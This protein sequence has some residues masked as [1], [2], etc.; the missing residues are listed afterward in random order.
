MKANKKETRDINIGII[1]YGMGNLR[2]VQNALKY[3]GVNSFISN[4]KNELDQAC[5]LILPGVGAFYDAMLNLKKLKMDEFIK[6]KAEEKK[7]L[8]GICLGMQ[9]LFSDG[10][11]VQHCPGLNIINGKVIKFPPGLKVPHMGWN[12]LDIVDFGNVSS[13]ISSSDIEL[14][15]KLLKN[16]PQKTY[17]YFVHSYYVKDTDSSVIKASANYGEYFPALVET[18]NNVFGAQFHPEKSGEY[19]LKILDNFI[20]V[21]NEK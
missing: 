21:V 5:G 17:V 9:V 18:E 10:Y 11:E 2:N 13:N 8:L 14:G 15:S 1:D 6:K 3:I 19:G 4:N 16:I 7:P 12:Q 20:E